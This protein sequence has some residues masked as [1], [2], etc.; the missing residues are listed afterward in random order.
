MLSDFALHLGFPTSFIAVS[1]V[2]YARVV[3]ILSK[4]IP[5]I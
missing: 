2:V 5:S 3:P 1:K 4:D